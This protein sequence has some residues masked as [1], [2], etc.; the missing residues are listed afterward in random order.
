MKQQIPLWIRCCP[1]PNHFRYDSFLYAVA[2]TEQLCLF[3]KCGFLLTQYSRHK[4]TEI[5]FYWI[6][7]GVYWSAAAFTNPLV[8]ITDPRCC[9]LISDFVYLSAVLCTNLGV[10]IADPRK[11]I[12]LLNRHKKGP[13]PFFCAHSSRWNDLT[14]YGKK[15][16]T[17]HSL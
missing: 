13:K 1:S 2:F 17:V 7:G 3:D 9:L 4:W 16:H 11:K 8:T 15:F 10:S 5:V 12:K 14:F 6:A